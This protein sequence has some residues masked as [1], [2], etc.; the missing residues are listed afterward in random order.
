MKT[1]FVK[2]PY[3]TYGIMVEDEIIVEVPPIAKWIKGKKLKEFKKWV[4]GEKGNIL[5]VK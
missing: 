4:K 1:Y 5:D 3:A 2:L